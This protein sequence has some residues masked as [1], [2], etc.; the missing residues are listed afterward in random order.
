MKFSL[1]TLPALAMGAIAAPA[2][3]VNPNEVL[4]AI[5][6]VETAFNSI[7][8]YTADISMSLQQ[9][10]PVSATLLTCSRCHPCRH[11]QGLFLGCQGGRCR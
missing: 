3:T 5:S 9:T 2:A 4:G 10:I 7:V 11:H 8:P 1:I 6:I